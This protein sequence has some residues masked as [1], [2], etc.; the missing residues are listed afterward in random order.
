MAGTHALEFTDDSFDAEVIASEKPVLVDFYGDLCPPCKALAPVIDE[1]AAE[2]EGKAK[3][4]KIN[5]SSN[6]G[7][8]VRF[9]ISGVPTV[10]AFTNGEP[11]D[12]FVGVR[13][14]KDIQ[15]I[16]DKLTG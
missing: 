7:V 2:N 4:G 8:A 11:V 13:P 10:I 3:I 1:L 6:P 15:R 14:K 12:K 16:L 9:G 5:T